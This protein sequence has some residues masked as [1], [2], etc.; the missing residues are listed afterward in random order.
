MVKHIGEEALYLLI[1]VVINLILFTFLAGVFIVKVQDIPQV[2]PI[3]VVFK[4][5]LGAKGK[6]VSKSKSVK[7]AVKPVKKVVK[8]D[9]GKHSKRSATK[10]KKHSHGK[11]KA[12]SVA[13]SE[14]HEKGDVKLPVKKKQEEDVSILASLEEKVRKKVAEGN[15]RTVPQKKEI[16]NI[17]AVLGSG[18]VKFHT[19]SRKIVSIPPTPELVTK[20][21][22]SVVKIKIW[23]SPSGKVVKSIIVQRSGDVKIDTTLM[24]YVRRIRFESIDGGDTQVGVISFTFRGG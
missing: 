6:V 3:K 5:E 1:S 17:S 11:D 13:V 9:S 8:K 10:P 15:V 12:S 21:F 14:T 20:E 18:G 23:V 22:P 24:N 7:K 16:G 2:E 19:G 4:E